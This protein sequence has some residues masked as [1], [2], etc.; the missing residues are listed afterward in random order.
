MSA[1]DDPFLPD[2][3][4]A[5]DAPGLDDDALAQAL[6]WLTRFHGQDRT[7]SSLF[8]GQQIDGAVGPDQ[9]VR[10]LH[11]AGWNAALVQRAMAGGGSE[12]EL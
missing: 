2:A 11:D 6:V 8:E 4:E 9:A 5:A 3:P 1:G 7:V 10:A 12:Y